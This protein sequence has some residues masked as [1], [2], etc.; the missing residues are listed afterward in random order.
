MVTKNYFTKL[1]CYIRI[2]LEVEHFTFTD[3]CSKSHIPS[4]FSKLVF[5][6][7]FLA[8]L[9]REICLESQSLKH[10]ISLVIR[11]YFIWSWSLKGKSHVLIWQRFWTELKHVGFLR[12]G[13]LNE[14]SINVVL[15]TTV[16]VREIA[17]VCI[18]YH[19]KNMYGA[20]AMAWS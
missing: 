14:K 16:S 20:R 19:W 15:T 11:K 8:N 13:F 18:Y 4:I 7:N 17:T 2:W 3:V 1:F 6:A 12:P 9:T 5:F 10:L